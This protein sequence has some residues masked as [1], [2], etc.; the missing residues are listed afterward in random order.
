LRLNG[1]TGALEWKLKPVPFNLDGDPDWAS[2]P[3]LLGARCGNTVASTQKDGWSYSAASGPGSGGAPAVRWQF[4]PTGIPFTSGTHGDT[5]YL[6]PGAG[7]N[8]TFITTTGGFIVEAGQ[9]SPGLTRLHGLDVC[10]SRFNPVR[11]VANIPA[12][13]QGSAYQLG[14]PTVTRGIVFVG[15]A[16][17]HLVVLA[18]PSVWPSNGSVCNNPE[19]TNAACIANGFALVPRPMVLADIDLDPATN[20]DQIFTEPVLAGGRVFVATTAGKLYMLEPER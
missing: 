14:P 4:P 8:D 12:T 2:G 3:T 18:D 13:T 19:V 17:G 16:R 11:W 7:W 10:G 9:P 1:S 15:T 6:I 5:R 20:S